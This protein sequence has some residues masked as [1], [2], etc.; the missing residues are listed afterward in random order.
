MEIIQQ[1]KHNNNLYDHVGALAV[2][3]TI[4]NDK[5]RELLFRGFFNTF[6][7]HFISINILLEKKLF[8]SAFA[9]IRVMFDS[10]IRGLYMYYEYSDEKI[11]TMYANDNWK[12]KNATDMCK[13]LDVIFGDNYFNEMRLIAYGGMCDYTHT[14]A[15]QIARNF[16]QEKGTIELNFSDELILDALNGM[17]SLMKIF[18][19]NYFE[20]IGLKQGEITIEEIANFNNSLQDR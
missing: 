14:G 18:S 16:N 1:L 17:Y 5:K 10:M 11:E 15:I 7:T 13:K 6:R 20:E 3:I 8:S 12:F 19:L 4:S 9:L 2:K